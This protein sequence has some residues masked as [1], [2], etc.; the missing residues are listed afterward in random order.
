MQIGDKVRFLNDVGG[1]VI[2]GFQDKQ[3]VLVSDADGFEIPTLIKDVVVVET[4]N[5]NI[6]KKKSAPKAETPK[7]AEAEAE[8]EETDLADRPLN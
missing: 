3:T 4:D 5:Y 2:T 8:A 7:S 6:A 1:G